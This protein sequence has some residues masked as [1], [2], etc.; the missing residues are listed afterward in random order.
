M[1]AFVH[2]RAGYRVS[3]IT[4]FWWAVH[5]A[6]DAWKAKQAPRGQRGESGRLRIWLQLEHMKGLQFCEIAMLYW[7]WKMDKLGWNPSEMF[8]GEVKEIPQYREWAPLEF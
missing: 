4:Q 3:L 8:F 5:V 6:Q 2:A 1:R 7:R